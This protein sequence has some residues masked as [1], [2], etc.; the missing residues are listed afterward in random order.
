MRSGACAG[1]RV[2]NAC[3]RVSTGSNRHTIVFDDTRTSDGRDGPPEV[4]TLLGVLATHLRHATPLRLRRQLPLRQGE[5][6]FVLTD[7]ALG[8][9]EL[10]P[11]VGDGCLLCGGSL[12][13]TR[14]DGTDA[15]GE[16]RIAV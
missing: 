1:T 2:H 10:F 14:R 6:T 3:V 16:R 7:C 12:E 9:R 13:S 8:C 5:R 15:V 11:Q 4:V